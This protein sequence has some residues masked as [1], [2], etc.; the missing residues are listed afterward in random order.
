MLLLFAPRKRSLF[1][2]PSDSIDV[3]DACLSD[4]LNVTPY[5][6][7]SSRRCRRCRLY[8]TRG[9]TDFAVCATLWCS[10]IPAII[11]SFWF[12]PKRTHRLAALSWQFTWLIYKYMFLNDEHLSTKCRTD[13]IFFD[14]T[15]PLFRFGTDIKWCAASN[16]WTRSSKARRTSRH[17]RH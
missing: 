8:S 17:W 5:A 6:K 1:S 13:E 14:W 16:G 11:R 2:G 12:S 4:W 10:R 3:A 15:L 9:D 7:R